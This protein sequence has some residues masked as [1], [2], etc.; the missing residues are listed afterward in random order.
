MYV[1]VVVVGIFSFI[2]ILCIKV[3][4]I[5][6]TKYYVIVTRF[7]EWQTLQNRA[8]R[9]DNKFTLKIYKVYHKYVEALFLHF[10]QTR[11]FFLVLHT[12]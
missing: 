11:S 8:R 2:L 5:V 9:R 1:Y 3:C 7:L 10:L 12:L 6:L 4:I